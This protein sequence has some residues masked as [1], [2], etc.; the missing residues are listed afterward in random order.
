MTKL[1]I[2]S[3]PKCILYGFKIKILNLF[4]KRGILGKYNLMKL[5]PIQKRFECSV[6]KKRSS[7]HESL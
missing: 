1:G 5:L 3:V 4:L 2:M 6:Y 7:N